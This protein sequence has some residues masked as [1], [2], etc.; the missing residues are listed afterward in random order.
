MLKNVLFLICCLYF[1]SANA[2]APGKRAMSESKISI[3]NTEKLSDYIFYWKGKY[4][5]AN[6]FYSDSTFS[7]PGSGGAPLDAIF[8]AVNKKTN[9]STDSL[10]FSNY[11]APDYVITLDTVAGTKILYAKGEISNSN[12]GGDYGGDKD[13]Y[14][15]GTTRSTKIILFSAISLIALILLIWFF[16]RRKNLTKEV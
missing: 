5:T 7:I 12:A 1:I 11:Y 3:K 16:I 2:D 8:W 4:D 10:F 13:Y 14:D 9:V 15:G 6:V